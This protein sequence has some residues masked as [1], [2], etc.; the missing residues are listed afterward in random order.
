[1]KE[2][3]YFPCAPFPSARASKSITGFNHRPTF[4][5]R[6][7]KT[8]RPIPLFHPVPPHPT[9]RHPPRW[10]T[11]REDGLPRLRFLRLLPL[12][13]PLSST[14]SRRLGLLS[15]WNS[16][17]GENETV[18]RNNCCHKKGYGLGANGLV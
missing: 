12:P 8:I 16:R 14:S 2:F 17:L 1:M 10:S 11:T 6:F 9:H 7:I 18:A 4:R 15:R 5:G 13:S 3:E